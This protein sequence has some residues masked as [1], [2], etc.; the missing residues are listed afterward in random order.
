MNYI[1]LTFD[2]VSCPGCIK[3]IEQK[4]S[5]FD[6]T[7]IT[8]I[9]ENSGDTLIFTK[10]SLETIFSNLKSFEGCCD[11]CNIEFS[12][13][14]I[15][16]SNEILS[17]ED[18]NNFQLI[19]KQYG[20]ALQRAIEGIEVSCSE[21]CV[22]KTT[23][24]D[25]LE[26]SS[27]PSFASVYNLSDYLLSYVKGGMNLVDFGSGTGHDVFQIATATKNISITGIDLTP[28]MVN[29][30]NAQA[31][32]QLLTQIKFVEGSDL[33]IIPK[34]S[35]DLIYTNNVFN[36]LPDKNKFIQE[37]YG[38]LKKGGYLIIADE[39]VKET[40]PPEI[41]NDPEFQC[42]GIS[43]AHSKDFIINICTAEGFNQK[44]FQ[45][46][47][48]YEIEYN[49]VKYPLETGIMVLQKQ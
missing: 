14:E 48:Q 45:M 37:S 16:E 40:L 35:Q 38:A 36:L 41:D 47:N 30:A 34:K 32:E 39:F 17:E 2:G 31:K 11:S 43:G 42:G 44:D 21:H 33:T 29:F 1:S 5:K 7:E 26:G 20:R 49:H 4:I 13:V 12:T 6:Q 27:I 22:C 9:S 23:D 15:I 25:R 10:L 28:E 24:F 19:K 46:I 18:S 8:N 3:A